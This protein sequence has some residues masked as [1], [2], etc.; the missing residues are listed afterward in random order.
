MSSHKSKAI[1]QVKK[2]LPLHQALAT[3][4]IKSAKQ[5]VGKKK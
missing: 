5:Y 2:A 1:T 3:G 4:R